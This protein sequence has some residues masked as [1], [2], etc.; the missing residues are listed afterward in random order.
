MPGSAAAVV[1]SPSVWPLFTLLTCLLASRPET[2]QRLFVSTHV[3]YSWAAGTTI[4]SAEEVPTVPR[5]RRSRCRDAPLPGILY[6]EVRPSCQSRS[7]R[8]PHHPGVPRLG[9]A[10]QALAAARGLI[11]TLHATRLPGA[12]TRR[13]QALGPR[14][15]WP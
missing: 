14:P 15:D 13:H 1:R 2:G 5:V 11:H 9:Q 12:W 6:G 3:A 10:E 8:R 7:G 4:T